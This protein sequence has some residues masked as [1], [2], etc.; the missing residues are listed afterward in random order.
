MIHIYGH[1]A[2]FSCSKCRSFLLLGSSVQPGRYGLFIRQHNV[3][4]PVLTIKLQKKSSLKMLF[5]QSINSRRP[6]PNKQSISVTTVPPGD[7]HGASDIWITLR[8]VM[9]YVGHFD[10]G[11]PIYSDITSFFFLYPISR[12][13]IC[14]LEAT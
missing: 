13:S 3:A 8:F 4:R 10:T 1:P 7:S 5:N 2:K 6:Y 9:K 11:G 14:C 12:K